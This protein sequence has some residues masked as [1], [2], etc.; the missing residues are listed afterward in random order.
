MEA[1]RKEEP[2]NFPSTPGDSPTVGVL[3]GKYADALTGKD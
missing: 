1:H 2:I 3:T